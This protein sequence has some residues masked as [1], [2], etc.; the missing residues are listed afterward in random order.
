MIN[1]VDGSIERNL[2]LLSLRTLFILCEPECMFKRDEGIYK[3]LLESLKRLGKVLKHDGNC[4]KM[5]N[6][7]KR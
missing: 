2:F 1:V 3:R 6:I 7:Y 4:K 5:M